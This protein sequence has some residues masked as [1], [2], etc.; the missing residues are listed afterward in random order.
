[1]AGGAAS[2]VG[3]GGMATK[4]A[5][6]K[7]AVAAGCHMC[8]ALGREMH[9]LRRIEAGAR[10][11]WFYPSASPAT[12]RKQWIA[13]A[14]KPAGELHVDEGA[15]AALRP[16]QEPAAGGR[17]EGRRASSSAAMH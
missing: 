9:P 11:T 12:V 16:R 1:M 8:V 3:S 10:C 6:A 7:I 14:L 2:A 5:A 13:G 17:D 15:A 4:I